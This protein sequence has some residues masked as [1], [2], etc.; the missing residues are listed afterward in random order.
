M[1]ISNEQAEWFRSTFDQLTDNL[2]K[3]VHGKR[4]VVRL[5]LTCLLSEGHILLEDFPGTGKTMLARALA[6]TV[7]GSHARVQFTSSMDDLAQCQLVVE[8]V[9]EHLD[10]K[11]EVFGKLDA[12][13]R[14][15]AILSP[16]PSSL[17][18]TAIAPATSTTNPLLR[19][20]LFNH[21]PVP[22]VSRA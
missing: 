3:A 8:A 18:A 13:V 11:K 21:D 5:A 20:A 14:P 1:T 17:A 4:H 19:R 10:L 7:Q 12:I 15:D 16:Q 6:N 2:E 9:P 22:R